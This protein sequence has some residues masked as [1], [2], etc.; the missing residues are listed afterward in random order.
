MAKHSAFTLY[1]KQ[2]LLP[3]LLLS[4]LAYA[5]HCLGYVTAALFLLLTFPL[6]PDLTSV[7][8]FKKKIVKKNVLTSD[9]E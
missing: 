9:A 5:C 3:R 6:I 1:S 4:Q 2:T 8:N 7:K